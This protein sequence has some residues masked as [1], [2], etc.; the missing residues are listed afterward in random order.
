MKN[1][2]FFT[3]DKHAFHANILKYTNRLIFMNDYEKNIMLN[4]DKEKIKKLIISKE[5]VYRMN[6]GI[7]CRN[8][9]RV[10]SDNIIYDI[11][12]IAFFASR[13]KEFRGE[14]TCDNVQ[15][16][17]DQF[18]GKRIYVSGNHDKRSNKLNIA[19]YR[20]ILFKGNMYIDLVHDPKNIL[21]SDL[22]YYYPLHLVAHIHNLWL[23]K[24][25]I[26]SKGRNSLLINVGVDVHNY[27]PVSFDEI[28]SIYHRWLNTKKNKTEIISWIE[29]SK[30]RKI[31][32]R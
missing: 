31:Y 24:E 3:A 8:N 4:G 11:G 20:I 12:D 25:V 30:R 14:G 19:N 27:Y 10:K 1:V 26:D 17:L 18:I 22:D 5:S 23:T 32:N 29:Q 28:M 2:I 7:L 15:L 16:Y 6:Q 13:C 9:E 21:I